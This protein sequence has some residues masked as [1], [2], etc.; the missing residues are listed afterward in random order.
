MKN[1]T[2]Q[3]LKRLERRDWQLLILTLSLLLIFGGITITTFFIIWRNS[4]ADSDEILSIA[5]RALG[6]LSLLIILFSAHVIHSRYTLQKV[7]LL[8]QHYAIRDPLTGLYNRFFFDER[9]KEETKRANRYKYSLA[10]LFCDLDH[11]KN[12]ND[13]LG[14]VAGDEALK[15]AAKVIEESVR[16]SDLVFRWG[17]DE[18]LVV[19]C[20][21]TRDGALIAAER[22]RKKVC[23]IGQQIE[24]DLDIS[25]GVSLYPDHGTRAEELVQLA[26]LALYKAKKSG[27]KI[28]IGEEEY[29]LDEHAIRMEFQ[30]IVDVRSDQI[31]GYEALSRDAKGQMSIQQLFKKYQSIGQLKALKLLCFKSQLRIAQEEELKRLFVNVDFEMLNSLE[32]VN[33]PAGMEVILEISESEALYDVQNHLEVSRRWREKGFKLALDDFGTGF[34]SLPFIAQLIPDYIKIDR[35][36]ILQAVSSHQFHDF[37]KSL[38]PAIQNFSKDGIIAEGIETAQELQLVRELGI[39]L[40]QGFLLGKPQALQETS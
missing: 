31:L 19:L 3:D 13:Q 12:I 39:T 32:P 6:G 35:S 8:L 26:D 7:K 37:L 24:Q 38:I 27:D 2:V 21:T 40:V 33:K 14:H 20:K 5:Y 10:F 34:M 36:T 4:I 17:G 18:I 9:M 30:P 23:S 11:F 28:H 29:W 16:A 22:I 1:K 15:S 25:I